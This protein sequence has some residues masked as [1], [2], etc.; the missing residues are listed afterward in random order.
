[1][2]SIT[3]SRLAL[4]AQFLFLIVN[5]IGLLFGIVFN[6][7][8]PDLYPNNAHHKMGWVVTWMMVAQAVMSLLFAYSGRGK[9]TSGTADER[10]A[11]LPLT[12]D[13]MAQMN[14][15]LQSERAPRWSGDSGQGT[16]PPS[17]SDEAHVPLSKPEPEDDAASEGDEYTGHHYSR[18]IGFDKYLTKHIP[19]I[20]SRRMINA[21]NI[22][23]EII[24]RT[25]LVLGFAVLVTGGVTYAGIAVS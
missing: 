3:R 17:P 14:H 1:M 19:S 4:P 23:Y 15:N 2:F 25:I 21:M 24:D 16:E 18:G 9:A 8:T 7:R 11:F 5:A 6:A 22:V 10:A 20:F 12:Q 13:A